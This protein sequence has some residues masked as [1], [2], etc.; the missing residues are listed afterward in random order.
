MSYI[1]FEKAWAGMSP[2]NLTR[3]P[4]DVA[5]S[6]ADPVRARPLPGWQAALELDG[7]CVSSLNW[8]Q[9]NPDCYAGM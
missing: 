5:A 2:M 7:M 8:Q 3:K 1:A 9:Q 4:G 6:Y